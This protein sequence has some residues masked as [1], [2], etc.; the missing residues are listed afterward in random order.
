MCLMLRQYHL[1]FHGRAEHVDEPGVVV[2]SHLF[3][4]PGSET[5]VVLCNTEVNTERT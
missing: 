2:E 1:P 4:L 3:G 5:G